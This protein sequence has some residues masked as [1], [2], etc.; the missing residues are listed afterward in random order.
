M[1]Y[2]EASALNPGL[3]VEGLEVNAQNEDGEGGGEEGAPRTQK[4]DE[5]S[6]GHAE[7]KGPICVQGRHPG[8]QGD[9]GWRAGSV[10]NTSL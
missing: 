2:C 5:T 9:L 3:G 10:A 1:Y 8:Q 4:D 6:F 7:T